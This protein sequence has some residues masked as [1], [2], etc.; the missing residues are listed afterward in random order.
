MV[1]GVMEMHGKSVTIK[2]EGTAVVKD[3]K[4]KASAYFTVTSEQF[5]IVIPDIVQDK[6]QKNVEV[7][8]E[9]IYAPYT[10]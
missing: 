10:K 8:V 2:Q 9:F 6:I 7:H 4:I 5:A 1:E 3:G